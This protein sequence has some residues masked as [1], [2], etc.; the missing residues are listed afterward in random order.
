M[1]LSEFGGALCER[2]NKVQ[3]RAEAVGGGK[4]KHG[5]E[6]RAGGGKCGMPQYPLF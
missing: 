6:S 5:G 1:E 4:V 2:S 3:R